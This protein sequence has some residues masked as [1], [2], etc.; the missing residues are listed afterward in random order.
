MTEMNGLKAIIAS[1]AALHGIEEPPYRQNFPD[2][3]TYQTAF[4]DWYVR[5]HYWRVTREPV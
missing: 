1:T 4:H 2:E 3:A 5:V